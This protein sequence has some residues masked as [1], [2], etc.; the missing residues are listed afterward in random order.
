M[1]LNFALAV[2]IKSGVYE[3]HV[4]RLVQGAEKLIGCIP[5]VGHILKEVSSLAEQEGLYIKWHLKAKKVCMFFADF[6]QVHEFS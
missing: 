2:D 6:Y 3:M 1:N 4:S 5:L